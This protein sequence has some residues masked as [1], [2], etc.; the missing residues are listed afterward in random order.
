M[1]FFKDN[2]IGLLIC[3]L[4]GGMV[5]HSP[6]IAQKGKK[7]NAPI[8]IGKD[9]KISY[10]AAQNGDRVPDFSYC[11]YKASEQPIPLVPVKVIVPY[12]YSLW[13]CHQY[14]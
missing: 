1:R 5:I 6:A 9:G 12:S 2:S 10:E 3:L 7:T 11:G 13:H 8:V 14:W 4:L